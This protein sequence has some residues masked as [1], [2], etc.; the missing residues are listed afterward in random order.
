MITD[1]SDDGR[2]NPLRGFVHHQE[3]RLETCSS[4]DH[5]HLLLS[6][7]QRAGLVSATLLQ[8]RKLLVDVPEI[9]FFIGCDERDLQILLD[10][11]LGEHV[12]RL[13]NVLNSESIDLV[14]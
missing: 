10:T 14:T 7:A 9:L 2:L 11:H 6:P 8:Y 4:A 12:P 1:L 5:Q 3:I 13:W